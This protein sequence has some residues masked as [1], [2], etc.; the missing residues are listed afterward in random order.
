[1]GEAVWDLREH[2]SFWLDWFGPFSREI[3]C[4]KSWF[5]DSSN[6][7]LSTI[8]HSISNRQ[9]CYMSV[10][11]FRA[12][13]VVFG[14]EKVF[15]DFDS[16]TK[17]PDLKETFMEVR[18][19]T[20]RLREHFDAEP[21][22]VRTWRGFHVY[23]FLR[24]VV[25]L[26]IGRENSCE[27]IY[28]LL[29]YKMLERV[30]HSTLNTRCLGNRKQLARVP[31]SLHEAGVKCLPVDFDGQPILIDDLSEYRERGINQGLF[32]QLVEKIEDNR[33]LKVSARTKRP[34]DLGEVQVLLSRNFFRSSMIYFTFQKTASKVFQY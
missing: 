32:R 27:L 33:T 10:Q 6:V 4:S 19:L 5:T 14:L 12:R 31:Y 2:R 23:V 34:S 7:F 18:G 29:Q 17:H 15:F 13:D 20:E 16:K 26:D 30:P 28:R 11:P 22:V 25:E 3:G 1:M 24:N 21:L 8:E 9:P